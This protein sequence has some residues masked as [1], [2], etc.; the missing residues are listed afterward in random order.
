MLTNSD[1]YVKDQYNNAEKLDLRIAVHDLYSKS[2]GDWHEWVFDQMQVG[3]R[4]NIIEFGCGSGVL[5]KKNRAKVKPDWTIT[6]TDGSEGMLEQARQNLGE[7]EQM[8]FK[9]IDIQRTGLEHASFDVAIANH[10]L[11]HVPDLSLAFQEIHRVLKENGTLYASTNGH[12]HLQEI[13]EW[14]AEFDARLPFSKP[15]NSDHFGLETATAKLEPYFGRIQ[16]KRFESHLEVTDV[17]HLAEF[18]F[19]IGPQLKDALHDRGVFPAFISFLESKRSEGGY[20]R[21]TKDSGLLICTK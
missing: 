11:Y 12:A 21:I 5:W 20:N 7:S 13:Y 9:V 19:S 1:E 17:L 10:M 6:L 4:A 14:V 18:I 3:D 2:N 15:G 16:L 8:D